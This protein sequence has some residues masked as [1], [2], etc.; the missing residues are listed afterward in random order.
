MTGDAPA[1]TYL[2]LM[3]PDG[4]EPSAAAVAAALDGIGWSRWGG[5]AGLPALVV[6]HTKGPKGDYF[7]AGFWAGR[8]VPLVFIGGGARCHSRKQIVSRL[9]GWTV[10]GKDGRAAVEDLIAAV[11]RRFSH[12]AKA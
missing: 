4:C 12:G 6:F 7:E 8:M 10:V 3:P 9:G 11:E 2:V 1:P 5:A